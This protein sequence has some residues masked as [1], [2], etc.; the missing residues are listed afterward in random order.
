MS[1]G[2]GQISLSFDTVDSE[3]YPTGCISFEE[4]Q[5]SVARVAQRCAYVA[6]TLVCCEKR[7]D[8]SNCVFYFEDVSS[9]SPK[10]GECTFQEEKEGDAFDFP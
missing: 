5:R 4:L 8:T 6:N 1:V 3:A 2:H 10:G 9:S 7:T